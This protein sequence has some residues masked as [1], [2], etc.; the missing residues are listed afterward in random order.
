MKLTDLIEKSVYIKDIYLSV[1]I[2]RV[3]INVINYFN[4]LIWNHL[5]KSHM[6]AIIVSTIDIER[7]D[8]INKKF[9]PDMVKTEWGILIIFEIKMAVLLTLGFLKQ[10]WKCNYTRKFALLSS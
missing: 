6:I 5:R 7:E 4:I 3:N 8:G 1:E 9:R 2:R 10:C